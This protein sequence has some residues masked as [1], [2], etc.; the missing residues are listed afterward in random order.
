M[1]FRLGFG[2]EASFQ[3]GNTG[4]K[5]KRQS[6][7]NGGNIGVSADIYVIKFAASHKV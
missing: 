2:A 4:T 1:K 5:Y 7:Y 6:A 3:F